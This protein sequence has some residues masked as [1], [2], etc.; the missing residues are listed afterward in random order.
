MAWRCGM[1]S[2]C[3]LAI[4]TSL[5]TPGKIRAISSPRNIGMLGL[6]IRISCQGCG[7]NTGKFWRYLGFYHQISSCDIAERSGARSTVFRHFSHFRPFHYF[8]C[9]DQ[10]GR[11]GRTNVLVN[12]AA[13]LCLEETCKRAGARVRVADPMPIKVKRV[14]V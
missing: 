6:A 11:G 2:F 3:R 10:V 13:G 1:P 14:I 5:S 7:P 12:K 4:S 9:T 8:A